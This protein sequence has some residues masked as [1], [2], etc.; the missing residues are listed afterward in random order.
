MKKL[1]AA[2]AAILLGLPLAA[3]VGAFLFLRTAVLDQR[4]TFAVQGLNA[5]VEI[6]RDEHGVAHIFAPSP[7]EAWFA[8]GYAH[9]Q[10][11]LAQM[12]LMRRLGSGRLSE[13]IGPATLD[14]D[15]MMRGLGLAAAADAAV[16]ALPPETRRML[17][18]YA[19]GVNAF[20]AGH[21]GAWPPEF[22]LLR[23]AP[24]PWRPRDSLLFGQ[25]M[26]FQ[27][28]GNWRDE[29][30]R[31]RLAERL[32]PAQRAE[33]WPDWPSDNSVVLNQLTALY[34]TLDLDRLAA[35]LP[36]IGPERASNE[37]VIAGTRTAT[38]RP[39]LVND[40]HLGLN[41]PGQWYLARLSAP[42]LD[43]VGATAAGVPAVLLGHNGRI[44][45]GFTT[46]NGDTSDLF[47]E[48]I[49]PSDPGRYLTETGSEP[50]VIRRETI[51]VRGQDDVTM[52]VRATRNGVVL[53]DFNGAAQ[54]AAPTGHVVALASTRFGRVDT[55]PR[56]LFAMQNARNWDEFQAAL[57]DW[58]AP[59]QNIVYA[60]VEGNIGFVA[61]ALLP[62]R[63]RGDGS[64]MLPGWIEANRWR[65]TV[66]FEALPRVFNPQSGRLA[67]ANNRPV[68][69]DFPVQI[70]T[71]PDSP[72]RAQ[73]IV[74]LLDARPAH[75]RASMEAMLADP[76]SRFAREILPLAT[77]R[78]PASPRAAAALALLR[79]W[80]GAMRRA[81]P[82]PLI[83]TAWMRACCATG[84]ARCAAPCHSRSSSRRGCAHSHPS[85]CAARSATAPAISGAS[86]RRCS[87]P[88]SP[89]ARRSA[90]PTRRNAARG[91]T[92]RS[93]A[94]STR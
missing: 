84:T 13:I 60:D 34:R 49:D 35:A 80:G 58:Q 89:A 76:V 83:F 19:R 94:R 63:G 67:N 46:T 20:L 15:R 77:G 28:S 2:L 7:D 22:Y 69:P 24:E 21:R 14:V 50:F 88:P 52:T 45:W 59:M 74:E 56:A 6:I 3:L 66:P 38:G 82:Q 9:A 79:D 39:F 71:D 30:L 42:G 90:A 16:E 27:L 87:A 40:P 72:Y 91:S 51:R 25:I 73:R 26:G 18:I 23:S 85:C 10:D 48:R 53:S 5:P 64:V 11:R 4:G 47:V 75:D 93:I 31:A 12:E 32:T 62:L 61:P 8:L 1:F 70:T 36:L 33:I 81:L 44:A 37:W 29:L 41:A 43:L 65:G 78:T 92:P 57:R 54:A 55:T 86:T 68:P 17:E